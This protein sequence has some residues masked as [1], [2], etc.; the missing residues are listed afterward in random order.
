MNVYSFVFIIINNI[1]EKY[2]PVA[3]RLPEIMHT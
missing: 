2:P 1:L 3:F